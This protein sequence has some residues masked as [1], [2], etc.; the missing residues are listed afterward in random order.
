MEIYFH[1][2]RIRDLFSLSHFFYHHHW[3][4]F[5]LLFVYILKFSSIFYSGFCI[6]KKGTS[7]HFPSS[8]SFFCDFFFSF[9][10][11]CVSHMWLSYWYTFF[12]PLYNEKLK[13]KE[14]K[15]HSTICYMVSCSKCIRFQCTNFIKFIR[16][17]SIKSQ[18]VAIS[19]Q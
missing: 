7:V 17:K 18:F 11:S 10:T 1:H 9:T 5:Y 14:E 6:F 2:M 8:S 16:L 4:L 3:H 13:K 15:Q 12:L 19:F